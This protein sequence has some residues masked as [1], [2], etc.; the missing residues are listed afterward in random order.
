MTCRIRCFGYSLA[1]SQ[2]KILKVQLIRA[3]DLKKIVSR[4]LLIFCFHFFKICLPKTRIKCFEFEIVE[5]DERKKIVFCH[6]WEKCQAQLGHRFRIMPFSK[7]CLFQNI[8]LAK[9]LEKRSYCCCFQCLLTHYRKM[10]FCWLK[11]RSTEVIALNLST[12]NSVGKLRR[13]TRVIK[14]SSS[15]TLKLG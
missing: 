11:P 6:K 5:T 3:L 12:N 7:N 8:Y 10:Y 1:H 14:R 4:H 15:L 2:K 9:Y 13:E